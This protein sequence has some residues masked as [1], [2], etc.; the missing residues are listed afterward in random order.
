MKSISIES[1]SSVAL[2]PAFLARS[3][4]TET[5]REETNRSSP[6]NGCRLS[7]PD[8]ASSY[9]INLASTAAQS[10]LLKNASMYLGLS[11]GL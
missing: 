11:A 5:N 7:E 10:M 6:L 3:R 1:F 9:L 2:S 8:F 4:V